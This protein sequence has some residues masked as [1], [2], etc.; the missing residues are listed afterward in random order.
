LGQV[1]GSVH[2]AGQPLANVLVTFIPEEGGEGAQIPSL[3]VTD[4]EGRFRLRTE[5]QQEGAVLGAHR[6]IVEDLAIYDAPRS[7]DGTLLARPPQRFAASYSDPLQSPL[8]HE[9]KPGLQSVELEL[10]GP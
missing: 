5:Q 3:G 2:A 8:T 7:P 6:I 9:V 4:K 10:S 1:E